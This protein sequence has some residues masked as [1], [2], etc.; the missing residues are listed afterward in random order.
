M[1]SDESFPHLVVKVFGTHHP[2]RL[3]LHPAWDA[4]SVHNVNNVRD[5]NLHILGVSTNHY[6]VDMSQ[7]PSTSRYVVLEY[8]ICDHTLMMTRRIENENNVYIGSGASTR[9]Q[10][11]GA[12]VLAEFVHQ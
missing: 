8:S 7:L 6:D 5:S 1:K 4:L 2:K 10:K 12:I 9:P 3:R 11:V